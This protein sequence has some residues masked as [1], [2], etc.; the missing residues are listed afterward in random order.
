MTRR[1]ETFRPR[2]GDR[3]RVYTCG[4]MVY[5]YAHIGNLRAY[6]FADTLRRTLQWK[7]YDVLHVINITDVG[8]LTSDADEGEDKV[9]LAAR[10]AHRSAFEITRQ[11]ADAFFA[12]LTR[13]GVR[14]AAV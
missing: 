4:P 11:Y 13:L 7:H 9:E 5:N 14:P 2:H 10:Q 6:M 12:D 1:L 3:A 8:H